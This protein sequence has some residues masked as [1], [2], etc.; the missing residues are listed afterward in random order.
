MNP[1]RNDAISFV[2]LL[3]LIFRVTI[4]DC[5]GRSKRQSGTSIFLGLKV[6]FLKGLLAGQ[7]KNGQGRFGINGIGGGGFGGFGGVNGGNPFLGRARV[8]ERMYEFVRATYDDE[9]EREDIPLR[10]TSIPKR[11]YSR[12][13]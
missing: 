11:F 8:T 7:V 3:I 9:R 2:F 5:T 13:G 12:T 10:T 6:G 4:V 1:A